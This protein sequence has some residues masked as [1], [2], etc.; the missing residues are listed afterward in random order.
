MSNA[1][2]HAFWAG[3]VVGGT[4]A[5]H[6]LRTRGEL[7]V[8]PVATGAT[9]TMLA[10]LPDWIEPATNPHHRQFFHSVVFLGGVC[11]VCYRVYRWQPQTPWQTFARWLALVV[12]GAY[13]VHLVC[14]AG[15]PR[16]LPLLG[17][18]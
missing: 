4:H 3:A 15:T 5:A 16:A 13:A 7:T 10:S 1:A 11:Y 2:T 12:G 9:A 6:D 18:L 17:K 14:D 8:L